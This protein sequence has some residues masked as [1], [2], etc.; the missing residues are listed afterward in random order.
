MAGGCR[1]AARGTRGWRSCCNPSASRGHAAF[2]GRK[3]PAMGPP[4]SPSSARGGARRSGRVGSALPLPTPACK[5]RTPGAP[6]SRR[7]KNGPFAACADGA[8]G[9]WS[10]PRAS[11]PSVG[12]SGG[13]DKAVLEPRSD[14]V[15]PAPIGP[16]R[17]AASARR[18]FE[19]CTGG[20]PI[21]GGALSPLTHALPVRPTDWAPASGSPQ[22]ERS[23]SDTRRRCIFPRV[24][25][26]RRGPMGAGA[27]AAG[28]PHGSI[29]SH[30][31]A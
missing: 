7:W 9:G 22:P 27:T 25:P 18:Q 10:D 15:A 2:A 14:A 19:T 29:P 4:A 8:G 5:E 23:S 24:R 16:R 13:A 21:R 6:A 28:R 20:V 12:R 31:R 30:D 11:A 1:S 26:R 3:Q 17:S